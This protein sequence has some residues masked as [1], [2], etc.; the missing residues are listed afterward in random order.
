MIGF[1]A[2]AWGG[3]KI[4]NLIPAPELR[5]GFIT[6]LLLLALRTFLLHGKIQGSSP[7]RALSLREVWIPGILIGILG[8]VASGLLGIGGGVLMIPLMTAW[9][10]LGQHEAQLS[11]LAMMLPPIGLPAVLVYA[12]AQGGLPWAI[13]AG[14]ATGFLLGAYLGARMAT[15]IRGTNLRLLFGGILVLMAALLAL[16]N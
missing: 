14:V 7:D 16:R 13:L 11:S 5:W 3:A 12:H 10:K 2:G 6:F 15:R 4:A 1:L 9:L 8:G